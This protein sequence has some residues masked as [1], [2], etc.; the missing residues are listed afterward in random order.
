MRTSEL[1]KKME[2]NKMTVRDLCKL[3]VMKKPAM[4]TLIE[5]CNIEV[6]DVIE[7]QNYYRYSDVLNSIYRGAI[8]NINSQTPE[9]RERMFEECNALMDTPKYRVTYPN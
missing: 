6:I 7:K 8:K 9:N 2:A 3:F 1:G 5:E 4:I